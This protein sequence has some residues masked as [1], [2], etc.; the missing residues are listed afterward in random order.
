MGFHLKKYRRYCIFGRAF[1]SSASHL[2]LKSHFARWPFLL[3]SASVAL[4]Q[5]Q[6]ELIIHHWLSVIII[7]TRENKVRLEYK[8]Y[9]SETLQ[10]F[11]RIRKKK[12]KMSQKSIIRDSDDNRE[13][14]E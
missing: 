1:G 13:W 10:A 4:R 9:R 3:S 6:I 12:K 11:L 7:V 5:A 2:L 14:S 8:V